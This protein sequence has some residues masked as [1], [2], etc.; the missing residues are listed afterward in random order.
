MR[1]NSIENVINRL[2]HMKKLWEDANRNYF[3]PDRFLVS[4]QSCITNSRTVTFILQSN[5]AEFPDFDNWYAPYQQKWSKDPV[6]IWARDARNSIEKRGDLETL[7]QIKGRVV[8][9][10][11][12]GPETEWISQDLFSSP[13]QILL[14]IPPKILNDPQVRSHGTL[15]IERRWVDSNLPGMEILEAL[16]YVYSEFYDLLVDLHDRIGIEFP[17]RL[18]GRIPSTMRSLIMDRATYISIKDGMETGVRLH[19]VEREIEAEAVIKRYGKGVNWENL[20]LVS[21]FNEMCSIFFNNARTLMS[22]DSYHRSFAIMFSGFRIKRVIG[23]D[24]PDRASRYVLMRD[25]ANLAK[26]IDA[27]GIIVIAEAWTAVGDNIPESGYAV[28]AKRRGEALVMHAANSAG[29]T[30]TYRAS[31]ERK[32]KKRHKVKALGPTEINSEDFQYILA[33]FLESWNCLDL[34]KMRTAD[35]NMNNILAREG[36]MQRDEFHQE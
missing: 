4:L 15:V 16:T 21:N 14:R 17:D 31:V 29:E 34:E 36:Q 30:Y 28:D 22:R 13:I 20:S 26:I 10:Y 6:M 33:P 8:A 19:Q 12:G 1:R 35:E 5:K 23:I 3:N 11:M 2:E 27:D 7:S 9:S 32:K 18:A 24:H 25:L